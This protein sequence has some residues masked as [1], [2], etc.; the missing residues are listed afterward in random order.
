MLGFPVSSS[1]VTLRR[2][3]ALAV[4][5]APV[6]EV[7]DD[8]RAEAALAAAKVKRLTTVAN[9]PPAATV[10]LAALPG[11]REGHG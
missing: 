8:A 1:L 5:F 9:K 3:A 2:P 11:G 6:A 10:A 7:A 4:V